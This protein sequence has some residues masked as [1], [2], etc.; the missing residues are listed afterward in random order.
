MQRK[1]T[2]I[3]TIPDLSD[4]MGAIES[5][6]HCDSAAQA[7]DEAKALVKEGQRNVR[8]RNPQDRI[9]TENDFGTLLADHSDDGSPEKR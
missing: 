5:I 6:T 4:A 2:V 9:F 3:A 7:V 8:I 1:Y